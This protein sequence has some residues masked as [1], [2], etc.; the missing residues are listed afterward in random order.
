MRHGE[1]SLVLS[2]D[3]DE[4]F[5]SRRWVDGVQ[6]ASVP[7]LRPLFRRVYGGEA[8]GG[9]VVAPTRLLLDLFDRHRVRCTF[10]VLGEV[11][12]WYPDLVRE[13]ARRGHEIGCHGMHHVDMPVLGPA[14]FAAQLEEAAGILHALTGRRPVGYRAPNLV[15]EPWAT[16][17]LEDHG[18]LFDATVCVSRPIGGKYHG[19]ANAPLH[20]YHPSYGAVGRPGEA[21]LVELPLPPFPVIRLSAGSGILTRILGFHW[22][23]TSLRWALRTGDTGFYFHPWEVGQRPVV[24]GHRLRNAVFLRRTGPWMLDAVDRIIGRFRD[25]IVTGRQAAEAFLARSR[26]RVA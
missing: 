13:I 2:V 6:S 26:D 12:R 15:Y 4:W 8:P 23:M 18:F 21:R 9:D 5:H 7:D 3:L 24:E 20:P 22:T 16:R 1:H 25:R 17:V 10:F 19:W 14:V 11:A